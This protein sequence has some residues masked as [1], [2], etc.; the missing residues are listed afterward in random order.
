MTL[1]EDIHQLVLAMEGVATVYSADPV[2]LAALKQAAS[3]LGSGGEA[4][5]F[6]VCCEERLDAGGMSDGARP[7]VG[8]RLRIGSNGTVPAPALARAVAGGIRTF[9][10]GQRPGVDVKAV[11]EISAIGV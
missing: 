5:V 9:V 2:W 6:V 10:S 7:T 8:V 11:V 3:R 1:E 4:A